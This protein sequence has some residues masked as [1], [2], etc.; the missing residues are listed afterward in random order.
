M[1]LAS[2]QRTA[3]AAPSPRSGKS[4][5]FRRISRR[6]RKADLSK[7]LL[8]QLGALDSW[9]ASLEKRFRP[10]RESVNQLDVS[11]LCQRYRRWCE[12]RVGYYPTLVAPVVGDRGDGLLYGSVADRALGSF[13]LNDVGLAL[14]LSDEIAALVTGN[15]RSHHVV[16]G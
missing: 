14:L 11:S 10:Q 3:A 12:S 9:R 1:T 8:R 16:T 2:L 13:R 5:G 6:G 15:R 4:G 7:F